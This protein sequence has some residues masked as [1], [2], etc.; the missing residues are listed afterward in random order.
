MHHTRRLWVFGV[1][2]WDWFHTGEHM[3]YFL[4]YMGIA[5]Y[6][7]DPLGDDSGVDQVAEAIRKQILLLI[8]IITNDIKRLKTTLFIVQHRYSILANPS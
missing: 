2:G 8:I 7:N 5:D 4:D 1:F 6:V 3:V